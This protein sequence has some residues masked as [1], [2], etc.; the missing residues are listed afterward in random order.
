MT[1]DTFDPKAF[2]KPMRLTPN[3]PAPA[4]DNETFNPKAVAGRIAAKAEADKQEEIDLASRPLG[5]VKTWSFSRLMAFENCPYSVYLK[6]V[7]KAPDPSGPAAERGTI[8]HEAIENY[9]Q[10]ETDAIR[11]E[12]G[13]G[14]KGVDLTPF[15]PLYNRLREGYQEGRVEV[16]GDWGFTR[17]W[18][19]TGFF[20]DD[21]WARVKLDAIEFQ[22]NDPATATSALAVD[23]KT[24]RRFGNELKHNQQGMVYAIAAFMRY[25][26]LE[27]VETS[28][29][30]L[31]QNDR[32]GNQ[33]T[34]SRAMLLKPM[35]DKRANKLTTATEFPPKP[36]MHA[37]K[38]CAHAKIQEGEDAPRCS[39]A[40][41][42]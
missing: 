1:D 24:G 29:E 23:H 42:E 35:W 27:F 2:K 11:P 8:I 32:M 36:S 30:Y 40:Y 13:R 22:G 21:V 17:D 20:A 31:D 18:Q 26:N 9:I 4:P 12:L 41:Q 39:F 7:E 37:C 5:Q 3:E 34:R 28:F 6:S 10:C 14:M 33:Y 25:P 16:E 19:Q 15:M 38:W